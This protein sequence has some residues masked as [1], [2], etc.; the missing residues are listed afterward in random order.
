M[1]QETILELPGKSE[2][3]EVAISDVLVDISSFYCSAQ[4]FLT[5]YRC[6]HW[7]SL[8]SYITCTSVSFE[9]NG[10]HIYLHTSL[11]TCFTRPLFH[12]L[13]ILAKRE[14]EFR[15][16]RGRG[17]RMDHSMWIALNNIQNVEIKTQ[18]SVC[19]CRHIGSIFGISICPF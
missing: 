15:G 10:T 4:L 7:L 8:A 16:F 3:V 6:L 11:C 14:Q 18:S 9:L 13:I 2:R 12:R 5:N 17:S 19:L 1:S